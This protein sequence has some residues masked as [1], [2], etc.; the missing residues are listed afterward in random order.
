L[1]GGGPANAD[2]SGVASNN[3]NASAGGGPTTD[4]VAVGNSSLIAGGVSIIDQLS[5]TAAQ[6]R[7]AEIERS[8]QAASL[9]TASLFDDFINV[10]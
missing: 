10:A 8:G 5:A 1:F 9:N 3:A 2:T 4:V 7:S 6:N